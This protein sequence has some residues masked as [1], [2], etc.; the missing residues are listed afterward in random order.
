M[1][2]GWT[3]SK[4]PQII[5]FHIDLHAHIFVLALVSDFTGKH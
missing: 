2:Y 4:F 3:L 1:D 5:S